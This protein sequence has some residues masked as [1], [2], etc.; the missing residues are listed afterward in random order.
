MRR[1]ELLASA[2]AWLMVAGRPALAQPR[3]GPVVVGW[4]SMGSRETDRHLLTVFKEALAAL[5]WREGG[6]V[7]IEERWADG[8][9]ER[10][11]RLAEE[12][13]ARQPAVVVAWP[14]QVVAAVSKASPAT[15]I[16][17]AY[18]ADPVV[19]GFA[20]SLARPGGM[21]TGLSNVVTDITEKLLEFLMAAAPDRRRVGFLADSTNFAR[22]G[23]MEAARRSVMAHPGIEAQFAEAGKPEDIEP[24]IA[25]LGEN[26]VD[27]LAMAS[28]LFVFE[29]RRIVELARA[30]GWPVVSG[31]RE[32]AEEGA[33]LSYGA[34]VLVHY[35]RA[36]WYVDRI[37][38]GAHPADLPV[39]QPI[40]LELVVN[41]G[42]AK[43]L[44]IA[45]PPSFL[46]RADEVIE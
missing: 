20:Q 17:Q 23:L 32:W 10:L 39:E 11:P 40:N 8:R 35:R 2:A 9:I 14:T 15:P 34:D 36:A 42:T 28:P 4:L 37:L 41:L 43:A 29:R 5:G 13:S 31:R 46:A 1:R 3:Q 27:S 22:Q 25:R 44:G 19:T 6:Q 33:L 30:R 16:V 18:A 45:I 38:K 12:L 7:I 21:V 24:A 26:N